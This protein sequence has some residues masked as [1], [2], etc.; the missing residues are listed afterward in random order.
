VSA[1]TSDP[2]LGAGREEA[3]LVD[4]AKAGDAKV[5]ASWYDQYYPLLFR[6]AHAR[7]G[8]RQD[9]EDVT[10]QVFLEALKSINRFKYRGRPVLAWLYGIGHNLVAS[11]LRRSKRTPQT[12]LREADAIYDL[13]LEDLEL[14]EAIAR[15]TR[16]QRETITLRFLVGLST[17]DVASVLGKKPATIYSLQARAV[18]ALKRQ[19]A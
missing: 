10:A 13:P 4:R 6:Y 8:N 11:K 2:T 14:R 7:L 15:L 17:K 9:A 12:A 5:W 19:L 18:A 1:S 3:G 16:D